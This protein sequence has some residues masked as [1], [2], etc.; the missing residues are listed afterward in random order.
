METTHILQRCQ[1][2]DAEAIDTL[3]LAHY[4][5]ICRLAYSILL[6]PSEAEEAAQDAFLSALDALDNFQGKATFKTWLFSITINVCRGRLRKRRV[7][8]R[9]KR[10]LIGQF[11]LSR[12]GL[13]RQDGQHPEQ[14]VIGNEV[15]E[16]LWQAVGRLDEKYRLPVILYYDHNLPVAE[17]A[18]ALH[19]NEQTIYT[20]L[21]TARER[22]RAALQ[23]EDPLP[24]EG[25]FDD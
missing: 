20:R 10:S 17:I 11:L 5:A 9:L 13:T 25:G 23:S 8:E 18:L 7:L 21:Y 14:A 4:P 3:F 24:F 12:E 15:R 19:A 16:R 6:D 22:L 1:A 2:G